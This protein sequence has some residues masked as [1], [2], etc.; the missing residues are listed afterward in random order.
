MKENMYSA[1]F[2]KVTGYLIKQTVNLCFTVWQ[3]IE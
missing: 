1:W 3:G 2:K